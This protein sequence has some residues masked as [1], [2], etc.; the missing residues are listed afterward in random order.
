MAPRVMRV[1]DIATTKNKVGVL[2]V[3]PAT[4]WRW[5]RDG[6]FPK[7]FKIG[8]SVTVWHAAEVEAFVANCAA[9]AQPRV[10]A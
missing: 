10:V 1:A 6:K 5:V 3:S 9:S 4:I 7:P 2:P 8:A